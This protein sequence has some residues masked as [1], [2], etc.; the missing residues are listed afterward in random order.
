[1]NINFK[2]SSEK[3]FNQITKNWSRLESAIENKYETDL[4]NELQ[5][6]LEKNDF[7]LAGSDIEGFRCDAYYIWKKTTKNLIMKKSIMLS[8]K[9]LCTRIS[10]QA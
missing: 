7:Y 3:I 8:K 10:F 1:M 9:R 2:K 5:E 4:F 6:S